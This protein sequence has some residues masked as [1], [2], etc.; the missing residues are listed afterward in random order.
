MK[1]KK[2]IYIL[3]LV[4]VG[5]GLLLFVLWQFNFNQNQL[6][7]A[8]QHAEQIILAYIDA[9]QLNIQLGTLEY[10]RMMKGI[11]LGEYPDLTGKNS[12]F[13]ESAVER[14]AILDY[15][16]THMNVRE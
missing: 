8:E 15:A 7:P 6:S 10:K 14:D 2:L 12:T 13:V 16:A 5:V 9:R 4:F 11:L 3:P 1:G